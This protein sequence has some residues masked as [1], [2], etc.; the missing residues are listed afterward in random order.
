M[1]VNEIW[2]AALEICPANPEWEQLV[3]GSHMFPTTCFL[4]AAFARAKYAIHQ[5][6]PMSFGGPATSFLSTNQAQQI[7]Q[8]LDRKSVV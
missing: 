6:Y 1:I 4:D 3:V 8:N 7:L 5:F 2:Q